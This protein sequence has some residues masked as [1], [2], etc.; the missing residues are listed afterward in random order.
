[1]DKLTITEVIDGVPA[2]V[3]NHADTITVYDPELLALA[4]GELYGAS[5]ED[6]EEESALRIAIH[7]FNHMGELLQNS[8]KAVL[9]IEGDNE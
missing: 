4:I 9:E 7:I 5:T 2:L 1:M 3:F 6:S 8:E